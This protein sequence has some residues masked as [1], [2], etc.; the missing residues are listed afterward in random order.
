MLGGGG[1]KCSTMKHA[2]VQILYEERYPYKYDADL[3]HRTIILNS[4]GG[5]LR[6]SYSC[7]T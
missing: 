3:K 7:D 2:L 5:V 6:G 4:V 1:V